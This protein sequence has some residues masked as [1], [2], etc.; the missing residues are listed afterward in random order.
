MIPT[1][2]NSFVKKLNSTA[3]SNASSPQSSSTNSSKLNLTESAVGSMT[4]VHKIDAADSKKAN[5]SIP[6][7]SR[8]LSPFSSTSSVFS[9]NSLG[10]GATAAT[11]GANNAATAVSAQVRRISVPL[12]RAKNSLAARRLSHFVQSVGDAVHQEIMV[13]NGKHNSGRKHL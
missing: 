11:N 10:S 1:Q 4:S 13:F 2:L 6:S 9:A 3:S 12:S 8:F 5:G 7:F